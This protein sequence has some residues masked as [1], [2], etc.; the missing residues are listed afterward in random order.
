[1]VRTLKTS[2]CIWYTKSGVRTCRRIT[3]SPASFLRETVCTASP[4]GTW[5]PRLRPAEC[6][7]DQVVP[8]NH[9]RC[10]QN[11]PAVSNR[12]GKNQAPP[13][14][15]T[16]QSDGFGGRSALSL[17]VY[18]RE[19]FACSL[20]SLNIFLTKLIPGKFPAPIITF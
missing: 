9:E 14:R 1:M 3:C 2:S 17:R 7:S 16:I 18:Q 11:N 6:I 19:G 12:I 8:S 20:R 4:F 13:P 15:I 5:Q 10:S